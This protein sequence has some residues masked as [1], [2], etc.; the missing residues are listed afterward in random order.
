VRLDP[1]E[2]TFKGGKKMGFWKRVSTNIEDEEAEFAEE[3]TGFPAE[4]DGCGGEG[5]G[6]G[7]D[8]DF[9]DCFDNDCP[10]EDWK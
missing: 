5:D 10:N 7:G 3:S 1:D 8:D 9:G 2:R 6:G 4:S